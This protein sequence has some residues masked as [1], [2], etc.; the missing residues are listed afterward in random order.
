MTTIEPA[1]LAGLKRRTQATWAAGDYPWT[2][3]PSTPQ[4]GV[5]GE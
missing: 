3:R 1:G 4:K 2:S 5:I